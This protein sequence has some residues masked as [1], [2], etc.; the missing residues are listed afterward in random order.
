M[1]A[2][3]ESTM[4]ESTMTESARTESTKIEPSMLLATIERTRVRLHFAGGVG[5]ASSRRARQ[6]RGAVASAVRDSPLFHQHD[7]EGRPLYRYPRIQYR[8]DEG[9]GEIVG[10]KEGADALES[11]RWDA[12]TIRLDGRKVSIE[13][14]DVKRERVAFSLLKRL[15]RH[16]LRS[17]VLVFSQKT[18][19]RYRAMNEAEQIL[20]RDRLLVAQSLIAL[21]GLG[22]ECPATLYAAFCDVK[23]YQCPYKEQKLL[24]FKGTILSNIEMPSGFALGRATSHGYGVIQ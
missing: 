2:R 21:R 16:H 20:E 13:E 18:Y 1:G 8:W 5:G 10:W 22:I 3:T 7:G 14:I 15:R 4:T 24:G 12:L 19:S 23:A 17:P 11:F 9:V 6:L